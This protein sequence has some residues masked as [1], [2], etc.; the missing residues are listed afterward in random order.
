MAV[1]TT[2]RLGITRW[3]DDDTDPFTREQMDESHELLETLTA[4]DKQGLAA[5]RPAAGKR[6][7]Y[8]HATDTGQTWRDNG[9]AWREVLTLTATAA[10]NIAGGAQVGAAATG[11]DP[12]TGAARLGVSTDSAARI[13]LAIKHANLPTVPAARVSNAFGEAVFEVD[14]TGAMRA[15]RN[16]TDDGGFWQVRPLSSA[17]RGFQVD[18]TSDQTGELLRLSTG[19]T[20]RV[21]FDA[22]GRLYLSSLSDNTT[23]ATPGGAGVLYCNAAGDLYFRS[24][25][26]TIRLIA[27]H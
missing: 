24:S 2:A 14:A 20:R 11:G 16:T 18:G 12:Q 15:G 25:S 22:K 9:A 23:P 6:G 5:A 19:G 4:I 13:G 7:T 26:G 27:A 10:A 21:S 3:S 8:Y 17:D 1:T